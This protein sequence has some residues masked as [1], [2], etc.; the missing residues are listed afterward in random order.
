MCIFRKKWDLVAIRLSVQI[1]TKQH[2]NLKSQ[3]YPDNPR[4]FFPIT[5]ATLVFMHSGIA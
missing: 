4:L 3:V 2:R 5:E 1:Y